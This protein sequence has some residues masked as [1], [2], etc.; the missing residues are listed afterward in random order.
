M[1]VA[2]RMP[3]TTDWPSV[4]EPQSSVETVKPPQTQQQPELRRNI[5]NKEE[6][7]PLIPE[8]LNSS[9]NNN[10]NNLLFLLHIKTKQNKTKT[11]ELTERIQARD[12]Q[13]EKRRLAKNRLALN[14]RLL[15]HL[16]EKT[17]AV[18]YV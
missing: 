13:F 8:F 5:R 7:K 14:N 3:P 18:V 9:M 10:V 15:V 17:K 1:T 2:Q 12:R 6:T 11:L 16:T 4:P